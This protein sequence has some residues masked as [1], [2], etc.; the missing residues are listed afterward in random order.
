MGT[1]VQ[2]DAIGRDYCALIPS[3][4]IK[5]SHCHFRHKYTTKRC[6]FSFLLLM[7]TPALLAYLK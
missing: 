5:T 7:N 1:R 4:T 6:H 2:T 3:T